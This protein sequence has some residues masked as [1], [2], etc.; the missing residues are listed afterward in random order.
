MVKLSGKEVKNL[1]NYVNQGEERLNGAKRII[2]N[3]TTDFDTWYKYSIKEERVTY[4]SML[5][6]NTTLGKMFHE[7][8]YWLADECS[9]DEEFN[10][11]YVL[12]ACEVLLEQKKIRKK[13]VKNIKSEIV[14]LNFGSVKNIW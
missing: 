14:M 11:E 10:I 4:P 5:S 13:D 1:I 7:H 3:N 12:N 6:I 9:R 8:L 2:V